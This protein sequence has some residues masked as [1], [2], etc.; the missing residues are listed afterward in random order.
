MWATEADYQS[1]KQWIGQTPFSS[2]AYI[3]DY[4]TFENGKPAGTNCRRANIEL[5]F[6][7][8]VD[9]GICEGERVH[10]DIK[11]LV[12]VE[13]GDEILGGYGTEYRI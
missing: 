1:K 6:R 4:S 10:I 11:L 12:I 2:A 5:N 3:N 9:V 7:R 13:D 8:E